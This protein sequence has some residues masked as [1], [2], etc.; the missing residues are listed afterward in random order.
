MV[1]VVADALLAVFE[2]EDFETFRK[3]SSRTTKPRFL[4]WGLGGTGDFGRKA[5]WRI[6]MI[7]MMMMMVCVVGVPVG[8]IIIIIIIIASRTMRLFRT[9]T[10]RGG[11][12]KAL[13][14]RRGG[15]PEVQKPPT[16]P[17]RSERSV[18]VV[19]G[20]SRRDNDN[21]EKL[22]G[23]HP[24]ET[25]RERTEEEERVRER[26]GTSTS[27]W[28]RK[29]TDAERIRNVGSPSLARLMNETVVAIYRASEDVV[30]EDGQHLRVTMSRAGEGKGWKVSTPF[31][32]VRT[33]HNSDWK[34]G[35]GC[36][37]G[38]QWYS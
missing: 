27:C 2:E 1:V 31:E 34:R 11:G 22:L 38:I 23:R 16:T 29:L 4:W 20:E 26:G 8:L 10:R 28:Q 7:M 37:C 17:G 35:V 24:R 21:Q 32:E 9:T 5:R 3:T 13:R 14:R 36:R 18:R 15:G 12:R 30:G 6:A 25:H 19:D 33:F